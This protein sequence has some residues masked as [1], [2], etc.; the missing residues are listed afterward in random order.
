MQY[1][2]TMHRAR[3]S[4]TACLAPRPLA[5]LL[6]P[7]LAC[8]RAPLRRAQR[9]IPGVSGKPARH[10]IRGHC[11]TMR[12]GML[13]TNPTLATP[14]HAFLYSSPESK[15]RPIGTNGAQC[16]ESGVLRATIGTS[17]VAS[18]VGCERRHD[19]PPSDLVHGMIAAARSMR[20]QP[21]GGVVRRLSA[22][23]ACAAAIR[24]CWRSSSMNTKRKSKR[25]SSSCSGRQEHEVR[26]PKR[27]TRM[28][29][30]KTRCRVSISKMRY[31]D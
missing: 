23:S 16:N 29:A 3:R 21:D 26:K 15:E 12:L 11:A 31:R 22:A 30:I 4:S 8:A 14:H 18:G 2:A 17:L 1:R 5:Q 24:C 7:A 10:G 25:S 28:R 13:V 27:A 9:C 20:P 6:A 19:H